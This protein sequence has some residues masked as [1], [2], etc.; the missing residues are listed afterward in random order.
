MLYYQKFVY[1]LLIIVYSISLTTCY[2]FTSKCLD[3]NYYTFCFLHIVLRSFFF[4]KINVTTLCISQR[5]S[6]YLHKFNFYYLLYWI[7]IIDSLVCCFSA[8]V[9]NRNPSLEVTDNTRPYCVH[10]AQLQGQST[11]QEIMCLRKG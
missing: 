1:S 11:R 2:I 7:C 5:L 10:S 6:N 9:F 8:H 3:F 4:C